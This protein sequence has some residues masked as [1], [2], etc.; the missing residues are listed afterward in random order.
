MRS[1]TVRWF[2]QLSAADQEAVV[3]GRVALT[4]A[5]ARRA[6]E[7]E[8]EHMRRLG[9][10]YARLFGGSPYRL[11]AE[12]GIGLSYRPAAQ[13]KAVGAAYGHAAT[14]RG[15]LLL[16]RGEPLI[17]LATGL[18]ALEEREILLHELGHVAAGGGDD[19]L[20]NAF[21]QGW[22]HMGQVDDPLKDGTLAPGLRWRRA[23]EQRM[24]G[25]RHLAR[26]R[27]GV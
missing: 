21:T 2:K 17:V 19:T 8:R 7:S 15:M 23:H 1:S 12:Q 5:L 6:G 14:G 4:L 22:A 13:I 18:T 16:G 27:A 25:Q 10:I 9:T 26:Q 20:A 24:E 11:A 3:K